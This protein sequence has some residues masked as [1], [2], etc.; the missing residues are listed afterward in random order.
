[1]KPS[2]RLRCNSV[3]RHQAAP[4]ESIVL[5][6]DGLWYFDETR[7]WRERY[8]VVRANYCLE[9]HESLQVSTAVMLKTRQ[10]LYADWL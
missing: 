7:K 10:K 4:E 5:Y 1:M 6:E 3:F 9:C 2:C 8:V